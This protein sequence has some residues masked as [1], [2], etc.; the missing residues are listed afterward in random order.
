MKKSI[1]L[2]VLAVSALVLWACGKGLCERADEVN[3][4]LA[5]KWAPC[6]SN[7]GGTTITFGGHISEAQCEPGIK[8]CNDADKTIINKQYDCI[9]KI[10]ACAKGGEDAF[11]KAVLD[12][13]TDSSKVTAACA[14]ALKPAS[15]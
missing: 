9:E 7:D 5:E 12:C 2:L 10:A 1:W 6:K 11:T 14:T 13:S 4:G 8:N 3:D 15:E